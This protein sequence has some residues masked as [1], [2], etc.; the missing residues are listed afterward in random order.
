METE[1]QLSTAAS[2]V[3]VAEVN[4][5]VLKQGGAEVAKVD[6]PENELLLLAEHTD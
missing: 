4:P 1:F 3:I 5:P 2:L 6:V